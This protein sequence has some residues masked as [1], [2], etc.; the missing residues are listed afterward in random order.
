MPNSWETLEKI[1]AWHYLWPILQIKVFRNKPCQLRWCLL[2]RAP[3]QISPTCSM[4]V[5][6]AHFGEPSKVKL[7]LNIVKE[8]WLHAIPNSVKEFPWRKAENLLLKQLLLVGQK[9]FKWSLMI[10]FLFSFLS[11]VMY[12]ISRNRELMIPIGLLIGCLM[13]DFL[14]EI[15]MEVFQAS[16]K[17]GLSLPLLGFSCCF[18]LV[19]VISTPSTQPFLL[20]V[21]NGGLM[22]GL[23]LWG[24]SLKENNQ[25]NEENISA[26]Q[27]I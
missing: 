2:S 14:K 11:D 8:R 9:A 22:Q 25:G 18:I 26:G 24:D 13:M 27:N 4:N 3:H 21:A 6:K 17:R 12:S 23:W 10:L 5:T 20:H 15:S 7:Q 19:K 1:C 16:E